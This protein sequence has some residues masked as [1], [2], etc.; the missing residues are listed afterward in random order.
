DAVAVGQGGVGPGVAGDD[1]AVAG[2]GDAA[3]LVLRAGHEVD[4]GGAGCDLARGAVDHDGHD[5]QDATPSAAGRAVGGAVPAPKRRGSN[6]RSRSGTAPS[7]T[8]AA[9]PSAVTGVSRIPLR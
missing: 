1:L 9:M 6:G 2:D 3:A 4:E 5:A 8:T 7:V